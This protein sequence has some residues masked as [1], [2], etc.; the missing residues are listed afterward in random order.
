MRI[1]TFP[2]PT[3]SSQQAADAI[4]CELDQI[5]KTLI[6]HDKDLFFITILQGDKRIDYE[7]LKNLLEIRRPNM[8]TP[9]E[10]LRITGSP[11]GGVK[12]VFET[13]LKV[14]LDKQILSYPL[15]YG[16]GGDINSICEISPE[17]IIEKMNPLIADIVL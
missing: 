15:V 7:K 6:F 3:K 1:I 13:N 4:G 16:G 9:D 12:P 11:A 14:I 17:E 8:A 5:I 2:N 10:V